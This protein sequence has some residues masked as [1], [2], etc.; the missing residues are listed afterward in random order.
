MLPPPRYSPR[1]CFLASSSFCIGRRSPL[2]DC[3]QVHSL[4]SPSVFLTILSVHFLQFRFF[5]QAGGLPSPVS[6][7][8]VHPL[9]LIFPLLLFFAGPL[10]YSK[11]ATLESRFIY[12][13]SRWRNSRTFLPDQSPQSRLLRT[14]V[15]FPAPDLVLFF[16]YPWLLSSL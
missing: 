4:L 16:F 5:G 2:E 1:C 8:F 10:T 9:M 3:C 15:R 11:R 7:R 14:A 6:R 13:P 12:P